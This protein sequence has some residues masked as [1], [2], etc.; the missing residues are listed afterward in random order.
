MTNEID[1][2]I[3]LRSKGQHGLSLNILRTSHCG[4]LRLKI[5]LVMG[6]LASN[7][8]DFA[9]EEYKK[10][11]REKLPLYLA[12]TLF[13][14]LIRVSHNEFHPELF[15]GIVDGEHLVDIGK[16]IVECD[17]DHFVLLYVL[18]KISAL[19]NNTQKRMNQLII[20]ITQKFIIKYIYKEKMSKYERVQLL[21][22]II[23]GRLIV[24]PFDE[25][26]SLI[27][28]VLSSV[29]DVE[30]L[31][32]ESDKVIQ[33]CKMV[34]KIKESPLFDDEIDETVV[35]FQAMKPLSVK[36]QI[37][38]DL[39]LSCIFPVEI[40]N[41][42]ELK[43]VR[44]GNFYYRYYHL[45]AS[46]L[47]DEVKV[48]IDHD[49]AVNGYWH[50]FTFVKGSFEYF[51]GN[52]SQTDLFYDLTES[53]ISYLELTKPLLGSLGHISSALCWRTSFNKIEGGQ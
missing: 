20:A 24:N 52:Y 35:F 6:Y 50:G 27:A 33:Y 8:I 32:Q 43:K 7:L 4:E 53:S 38:K 19:E 37:L 36:D 34:L 26:C 23:N 31:N 28:K 45:L 30:I 11:D 48:L 25:H 13:S 41:S 39:A 22:S 49:F 14:N 1:F 40:T 51:R 47:Q 15:S 21:D 9:L 44:Y 2:A 18:E 5:Q 29:Q 10:L 12:E 16:M 42:T 17:V 46:I 3:Q